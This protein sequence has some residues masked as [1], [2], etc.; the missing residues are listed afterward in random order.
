MTCEECVCSIKIVQDIQ[1]HRTTFRHI[2]LDEAY[3]V[4]SVALLRERLAAF[5]L[6]VNP[7]FIRLECSCYRVM[8]ARKTVNEIPAEKSSE[9][10]H[11]QDSLTRFFTPTNQRRSRVAQSSFSLESFEPG[12]SSSRATSC[13]SIDSKKHHFSAISIDTKHGDLQSTPPHPSISSSLKSGQSTPSPHRRTDV[14]F[15]ALSPYFSATSEK[16]R[17]FSK[18]QYVHLSGGRTRI[19]G[20]ESTVVHEEGAFSPSCLHQPHS[21]TAVTSSE[22]QDELSST[23]QRRSIIRPA[24]KKR[25]STHVSKPTASY[26]NASPSIY[27]RRNENASERRS[28]QNT[29]L[30]PVECSSRNSGLRHLSLQSS[31]SLK[32]LVPKGLVS[33]RRLRTASIIRKA[34]SHK[35]RLKLRQSLSPRLVTR[36]RVVSLRQPHLDELNMAGGTVSLS[37]PVAITSEDRELYSAACNLAGLDF[38]AILSECT[39]GEHKTFNDTT[40]SSRNPKAIRIGNFE[41]E[42]WYSAP[43]PAEYAQLSVLYLCEYCMK[44]MKSLEMRQRHSERC[45][46]RHPPGNEIYR[47]DGVSVFEVDG[48]CSR[49]YCQNICLLAKLFLDHKTLYYDV[50]PFLFYVVTRNDSSGCHFVGYFSKEKYSAQKYN[51]SCIMTLPSYQRQGFG[52]FLIDFSFLLS[53]KEGMTG[54]PERPLSDLGRFSYK[55]YWRSAICEYLYKNISP[56]KTKRLTLRGI[57]RGTGISVYDVMETLQSLNILQRIDSQ[58]VIVLNMTMLKSHWTRAKND[59]KRIWLDE[60]KLSWLPIAH[61]PSKEY[62]ERSSH[63]LC[64][65]FT[66]PIRQTTVRRSRGN[67]MQN[68][69]SGG[70][71]QGSKTNNFFREKNI[72]N[73]KTILRRQRY[74]DNTSD[75]DKRAVMSFKTTCRDGKQN[76]RIWRKT[77]G[78]DSDD[79]D[80]KLQKEARK[81]VRL[82]EMSQ[83]KISKRSTT[84]RRFRKSGTKK[85]VAIEPYTYPSSSNSD[86]SDLSDVSSDVR[87]SGKACKPSHRKHISR[88]HFRR[89]KQ[90]NI[91]NVESIELNNVN[92]H[93]T[94]DSKRVPVKTV[95]SNCH[96]L[97]LYHVSSSADSIGSEGSSDDSLLILKRRK[98]TNST[99]PLFSSCANSPEPLGNGHKLSMSQEPGSEIPDCDKLI[100]AN[101]QQ[102]NKNEK[103]LELSV[104]NEDELPP[105]LEAD[106]VD[107]RDKLVKEW[108]NPDRSCCSGSSFPNGMPLLRVNIAGNDSAYEGEDEDVPPRLSP[109]FAMVESSDTNSP[110]EL[111]PIPSLCQ[112]LPNKSAPD[113]LA[114][115]SPSKPCDTVSNNST[116]RITSVTNT[117]CEMVN[118]GGDAG[119]EGESE[120]EQKELGGGHSNHRKNGKSEALPLRLETSALDRPPKAPAMLSLPN[121]EHDMGHTDEKSEIASIGKDSSVETVEQAVFQSSNNCRQPNSILNQSPILPPS[122]IHSDL[123]S[124]SFVSPPCSLQKRNT[125]DGSCRTPLSQIEASPGEVFIGSV[126]RNSVRSNPSTPHHL[127]TQSHPSSEMMFCTTTAGDMCLTMMA[128]TPVMANN[129]KSMV[130]PS[131]PTVLPSATTQHH[132]SHRRGSKKDQSRTSKTVSNSQRAQMFMPPA[133]LPPY[134][135]AAS[136]AGQSFMGPSQVTHSQT[137]SYYAGGYAN[138][139]HSAYFDSQFHPNALSTATASATYPASSVSYP[140]HLGG[141]GKTYPMGAAVQSGFSYSYPRGMHQTGANMGLSSG[142][143]TIGPATP[144]Q[145]IGVQCPELPNTGQA[146]AAASWRYPAP[147]AAFS[148]HFMDAFGGGMPSAAGGT[149]FALPNQLY[150]QHGYHPY[151]MPMM[152]ND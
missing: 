24:R 92:D 71:M 51:L 143:G 65:P 91:T 62:G 66:S 109:N 69:N 70:G 29:Y 93:D 96:K 125:S 30:F 45:Q 34:K 111:E 46:L 144:Q 110:K 118:L 104:D 130:K 57:A 61:S 35:T 58:M 138:S 113:L 8:P 139:R 40:D 39:P 123:S 28:V 41:I 136:S 14:L 87:K 131:T 150:Y 54:T 68:S 56:D 95:N 3:F 122:S 15:D 79:D 98:I 112:T 133:P 107:G 73:G 89:R 137:G 83:K 6:H 36:K 43:Y 72:K 27:V 26:Q 18:G 114:V 20:G 53:R 120:A 94:P 21:S 126:D 60:T 117:I 82:A 140:S 22:S 19:K 105:T 115:S 78:D 32:S 149:Q 38:N 135:I 119:S 127:S 33:Q 63:V 74:G 116:S 103:S 108:D 129:T 17:T 146:N 49:I 44:Y 12:A 121:E 102:S 142:S 50:E 77:S 106:G 13:K 141:I 4:I 52:R 16:R 1:I 97:H 64:S 84:N 31:S 147:P 86:S 99:K 145:M 48:Y 67:I 134:V 42:T 85:A 9:L 7:A 88:S 90:R 132:H 151:L 75:E 80:V 11:L 76:R 23:E 2:L 128:E 10:K 55:S 25:H 100:A 81:N 37:E 59:A 101:V 47:K 124:Q 5:I 148:G 152:R